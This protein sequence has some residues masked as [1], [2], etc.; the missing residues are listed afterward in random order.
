M[1]ILFSNRFIREDGLKTENVVEA[2]FIGFCILERDMWKRR[3]WSHKNEEPI[4]VE[5]DEW[6]SGLELAKSGCLFR[7]VHEK[8]GKCNKNFH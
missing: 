4:I 3:Q 8:H 5:N 6:L 1:G 2:K 7:G